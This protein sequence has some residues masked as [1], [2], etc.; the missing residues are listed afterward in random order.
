[1]IIGGG[2]GG[3]EAALCLAKAK[4]PDT[5][6][7]ILEPKTYF[8]Y[9]AA[10]YRFVTG[11]S[12]ME[13]C[14]P[15][16]DMFADSGI[17]IVRDSAQSI[18]L[19]SKTVQGVSGS[20]YQY[21]TLLIALG[22]SVTTFGIKGVSKHSF[23]MKSA[24]EALRLKNHIQESFD[25]ATLR[26]IEAREP[27]LHTV[28]VGGGASGIELAGEIAFFARTLASRHGL[29]S[30]LVHIDLIEGAKRLLPELPERVSEIA[31]KRLR[32]LG[33]NVLL[34]ERVLREEKGTVFL[35]DKE[36]CAATV[37]WTAGICGHPLLKTIKGWSLDQ[38]GRVE[39]DANLQSRENPNVFVL[40]DS[41]A[42]PF[43]GMAQTALYDGW[44]VAE[45][46]RAKQEGSAIPVYK[47][48][49]PVFAIPVG[50]TF[51]VVLWRNRIYT[52]YVGWVLRRLL[53]LKIFICLLPLRKA[54][55]AFACGS[56]RMMDE[57]G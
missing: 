22:S 5:K 41:A 36:I 29:S 25:A 19:E 21:D 27:L 7:R 6:I 23:G 46:L 8:E 17:E 45:F 44:Y 1:M 4:L 50:S 30:S 28:I 38:R 9:H 12:P 54:L 57:V 14:I 53:D 35:T 56:R 20:R 24:T 32:S 3:C 15:Y 33:V 13:S 31:M 43:S 47:P 18:G 42:T 26:C 49:A 16:S 51:A 34:S 48:P 55:L 39:V 37:V 52:G 40:G 2:F 10:L 11:T